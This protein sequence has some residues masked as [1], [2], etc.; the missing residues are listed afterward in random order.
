MPSVVPLLAALLL[1]ASQAATE[2]PL[3]I[4]VLSYRGADAARGDFGFTARHLRARLADRGVEVVPLTL[5]GLDTAA[6]LARVDFI[7]TNPGHSFQLV[8]RHGASRLAT[9]RYPDR[10]TPQAVIGATI[11][12]P[13]DGPVRALPDLVDRRLGVVDSAAFGGYLL[14]RQRLVSELGQTA[15]RIGTVE[16]GFPQQGV[17]EALRAGDVE[18][19]VLRACLLETLLDEGAVRP[20]EFRVLGRVAEAD[21]PCARSTGLHPGW[22]MLTL[23]HVPAETATQVLAALLS[24]PARPVSGPLDPDGWLAPVS[25]A[26]V[27]DV[28]RQLELYPFERDL[29]GD[30]RAWL[31]EN[32]VWVAVAAI[33]LGAFLLHVVRVEYLV[34]RRTREL[35]E[36]AAERRA[37]EAEMAHA[38][39]VSS[40]ATL[41]GSLAHD[42]NQPLAA[43][44]SFAGGLRQ[45]RRAGTDDAEMTEK[46]LARIV[47][48]ANR[49]A[50]FIRSMRAFLS[51][52]EGARARLD[53][54][55]V[56]D[57]AVLLTQ[58]LARAA[59]LTL[60][61]RRP[62]GPMPV[63]GDAPRLRQVFVALIQ[64]AIDA[65]P[66][67]GTVT[68]DATRETPGGTTSDGPVWRVSVADSGPGL[69]EETR[70][71]ATEPFFTTKGEKG[72]G[73]GLS[74]A[75]AIVEDHGG[76]LWLEPR[77]GGGTLAV[78]DLPM[79]PPE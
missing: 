1:L 61:W 63:L 37:L 41:A 47:E 76:R 48:Q 64:N 39:R 51:R 2:T 78:M 27:E 40:M 28:Y 17:L 12:A 15:R 50:D 4:G 72:L 26:S 34:V 23:P 44:A 75:L 31:S 16:L 73:L 67:G 54:R 57:D 35:E 30:I 32:V 14:A 20:G 19:G 7:F 55:E 42:L 11:V 66:P 70:R 3:R 62:A 77:A 29:R 60:D 22:A 33:L 45:R 21:D 18:A 53:L 13:A 43:I 25:Y 52:S 24:Q 69:D 36:A 56:A 74:T 58:G 68:V 9:A 49:A 71:R 46:V 38:N 65:S 8:R 5:R 10:A 6:R 79:E 59:A